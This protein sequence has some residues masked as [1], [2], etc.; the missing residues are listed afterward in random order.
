MTEIEFHLTVEGLYQTSPLL[1]N[2]ND[3]SFLGSGAKG[4]LANQGNLARLIWSRTSQMTLNHAIQRA[5]SYRE[6]R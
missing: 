5:L 6:A 4:F 3:L 1:P 2:K